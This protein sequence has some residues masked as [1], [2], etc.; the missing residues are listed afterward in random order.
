MTISANP[1]VSDQLVDC[2]A[3]GREPT[4]HELFSQAESMWIDG[5]AGRSA[6]SWGQMARGSNERM[7]ALRHA[8]M[9][10]T[11]TADRQPA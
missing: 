11:G 10:L 4:I 7:R 6:F 2:I 3:S 1:M 5:A 8:Q 9:A